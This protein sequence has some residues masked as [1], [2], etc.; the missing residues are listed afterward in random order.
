MSQNIYTEAWKKILRDASRQADANG[1]IKKSYPASEITSLGDRRSYTGKFFAWGGKTKNTDSAPFRDLKTVF[2]TGSD[3]KNRFP[4]NLEIVLNAQDEITI[5]H[6]LL[7][8]DDYIQRYREQQMPKKLA[9]EKYKFRLVQTFQDKW[10]KYEQGQM[11]FT[12]LM[13]GNPF[14]NLLYMGMVP[15]IFNHMLKEK[16]AE[17]EQLLLALYDETR[18]LKDR[19]ASYLTDFAATY[20]SL[21]NAG[22]NTGQ[23]ERTIATLLTFR[24]PD[25]YTLFKW[26]FYSPLSKSFGIKP[27]RSGEQLL[28]YYAMADDLIK[29]LNSQKDIYS[30]EAANLDADCYPDPNHLLLAQD[31]FYTLLDSKETE[32]IVTPE[33]DT[34]DGGSALPASNTIANNEKKEKMNHPLNLILY[35]PPGTGK[36]YHTINKAIEIANPGYD[37]SGK[38][39]QEIK[40]EY[41][42]LVKDGRIGF[43]TFHQSLGYEDFIEGIKP[44]LDG[45]NL[46][47]E[48]VPGI[49]KTIS[50]RAAYVPD[51]QT[52][53]FSL[54]PEEFDNAHF[55]K[56][57]LGSTQN[58]DDDEIYEYCIENGYIALGW[59]GYNDYTGKNVAEINQIA[60]TAK[61]SDFERGAIRM[62]IHDLKVGDFVIVTNGNYFF[63]AVGKVTGEYEYKPDEIEYPHLRKVEWLLKNEHIPVDEVYNKIFS[64]R[65]IY[66]LNW[67]GIKREFFVKGA[68]S[69]SQQVVPGNYVLIIDEINRGNVSAIFGEL[70]TLLEENKRKGNTEELSAILPYSREQFSVPNNLY[71]IGTMNTADRSV[72]ALDTALRRRFSFE[73][74]MPKDDMDEIKVLNISGS[75]IDFKE[76]LRTINKRLEKI[77]SR[78]HRIGHSYFI[79]GE[80]ETWEYYLRAF[81]NKIIPLLQE[82]FYG[83]YA[84]VCLVLGKGFVDI[85]TTLSD[86]RDDK[87]FAVAEHDALDD[88]KMKKVWSVKNIATEDEFAKALETLLNK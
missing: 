70:I 33:E 67:Y 85:N 9:D 13:S 46:L 76:V 16:P 40:S 32:P 20:F 63:R 6:Q 52:A 45:D 12:Q 19:I 17:F 30:W 11:S 27:K 29:A 35:G 66:R 88:F 62:F 37:M 72:E 44:K 82:Y 51:Q 71:V 73:E 38:T 74:M 41:D 68:K 28:H 56:M 65:S 64:Q 36:T 75:V 8:Y 5:N 42:R 60:S 39:R 1:A 86:D 69:N 84:N 7:S 21:N 59:G 80:D 81:T 14:G 43:C 18:P 22:K 79:S 77:V 61:L 53:I 55:Y 54:T 47:Y 4:G 83:D 50:S 48:L 31:I 23:D 24:H 49:F 57:S 15:S 26:G 10:K 58:P 78:D 3:F 34:I 2:E 87:F 25:K